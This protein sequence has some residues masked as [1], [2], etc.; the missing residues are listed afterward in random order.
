[1][2]MGLFVVFDRNLSIDHDV[3]VARSRRG[4]AVFISGQVV[5]EVRKLVVE[6]LVVV[7]DDI[8]RR[9]FAKRAS[10]LEPRAEGR[11][12]TQSPMCFLESQKRMFS[13][14][15]SYLNVHSG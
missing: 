14:L 2:G 4:D 6:L 10:I 9:T 1:M 7:D 3:P 11:E 5:T 13:N 12:R 8:R 15:R